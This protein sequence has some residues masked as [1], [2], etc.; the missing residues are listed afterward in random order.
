MTE[1]SSLIQRGHHSLMICICLWI[2]GITLILWENCL[3][4]CQKDHKY[5]IPP[6][7]K[8]AMIPCFD[9][10]FN[11]AFNQYIVCIVHVVIAWT[12]DEG[13]QKSKFQFLFEVHSLLRQKRRQAENQTEELKSWNQFTSCMTRGKI[14]VV[15]PYKHS[16]I[17]FIKVPSAST[18]PFP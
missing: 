2:P 6:K 12:A 11:P 16:F 4:N 8:L 15:S 10:L 18:W 7:R 3:L 1:K 14:Y 9:S 5:E 17:L 13:S